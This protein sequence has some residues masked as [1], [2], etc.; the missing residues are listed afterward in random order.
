M[1]DFSKYR[2]FFAF[3]CSFTS[4]RTPT[5]ADILANEMPDAEYYNFGQ[6]G[7]GNLLINNRVAQANLKYEFD[8]RDLVIVMFTSIPREDRYINGHWHAHGN[9]FNQ[10]YY[11]KNFVKNYCDPIG[12]LA[13]D[14]ALIEMTQSY[15][16]SLP[17]NAIFLSMVN[18]SLEAGLLAENTRLKTSISFKRKFKEIYKNKLK[19]PSVITNNAANYNGLSLMEETGEIRKDGHPLVD[20]YLIF[21][22]DTGFILTERSENYVNSVMDKLK[23][24]SYWKDL[25]TV[26]PEL[27]K[28]QQYRDLNLI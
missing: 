1:L 21:L 16:E 24:V 23:T 2:R 20:D 7:S 17:C 28:N 13:R 3:G 11:D 4:Y 25:V 19:F 27:T 15:L 14:A 9:V 8:E 5:W 10:T 6:G 12:Y 22:K 18:L 26:F